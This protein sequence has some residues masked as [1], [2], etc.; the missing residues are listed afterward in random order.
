MFGPMPPIRPGRSSQQLLAEVALTRHSVQRYRDRVDGAAEDIDRA[1]EQL[2]TL[3]VERGTVLDSPPGWFVQTAGRGARFVV[4]DTG[5]DELVIPIVL[6]QG[7][8]YA[9]TLVNRRYAA[10]ARASD[11]MADLLTGLALPDP[12]L[13]RVAEDDE[14]QGQVS[15]RLLRTFYLDGVV[16]DEP[17]AWADGLTGGDLYVGV[18]RESVALALAVRWDADRLVVADWWADGETSGRTP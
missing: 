17:P 9:T 12:L 6:S 4:I 11:E 5:H 8:W 3:I 16:G 1:Q 15:A 13:R 7:R 14:T 10:Q 18:A 2:Q